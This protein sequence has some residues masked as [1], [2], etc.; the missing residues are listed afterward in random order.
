MENIG[1]LLKILIPA[2]TVLYGMYLLAK[3][4]LDKQIEQKRLETVAQNQQQTLPLRLQAYERMILF[5]E[6]T[7]SNNLLLRL[8]GNAK[9]AAE[10][11][12][13]MINE[14]RNEFQHNLAQQL[15]IGAEVWEQ[16]EDAY[17]QNIASLNQTANALPQDATAIEFAKKILAASLPKE[18]DPIQKALKVLKAEAF[19]LIETPKLKDTGL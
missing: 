10:L 13:L 3:T 15:Y 16:I 11:H 19:E 6:R 18:Q 7:K 2:A 9:S 17:Q 12:F 14:I 4:F 5:L 8:Q 1:E